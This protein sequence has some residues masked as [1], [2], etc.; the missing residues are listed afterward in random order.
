MVTIKN[1]EL[2]DI[3]KLSILYEELTNKPTNINKL[4]NTYSN[5]INNKDYIVLGA[6]QDDELVGSLMGIVCQDLVG[7]CKPFMVIENVVVAK[8]ARRMGIGRDLMIKIEQIA[9]ERDC[10][11]IIF[12]SGGQRVEAHAFYKS[13]G[14]KEENVE[15]YRKHL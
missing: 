7:E 2:L 14:F 12:V 4:I 13:L 3:Q 10:Y 6:Y 15:G 11:Y 5:L 1:I 9:R 8:S